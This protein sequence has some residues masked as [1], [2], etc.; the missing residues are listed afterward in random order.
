M[1]VKVNGDLTFVIYFEVHSNKGTNLENTLKVFCVLYNFEHSIL[2]KTDIYVQSEKF[3]GFATE[4]FWF[5][6][7]IATDVSKIR[8]YPEKC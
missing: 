5:S 7:I 4:E 6:R 1:S 2:A 8:I 3:F